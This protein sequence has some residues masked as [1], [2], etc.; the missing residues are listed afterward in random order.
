VQWRKRLDPLK[1]IAVLGVLLFGAVIWWFSGHAPPNDELIPLPPP[2]TTL[3]TEPAL[4]AGVVL[5]DEP[6]P[7]PERQPRTRR[8]RLVKRELEKKRLAER[9]GLGGGG[10]VSASETPVVL[11]GDSAAQRVFARKLRGVKVTSSAS[12]GYF[13]SLK[14][15]SGGSS[16]SAWVK[17][18]ATIAELPQKKLA[19]ALSAR[20][21]VAGEGTDRDELISDASDACM[22]S[23]AQDV[24]AWI[25]AKR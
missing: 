8:G 6:D 18:S 1:L 19:S 7:V 12:R 3:D 5:A 17:C 20:A 14:I 2:R 11:S 10:D 13:V 23:L 25:R 24:S 4:D 9:G 16:E 22:A 21:E 15:Q